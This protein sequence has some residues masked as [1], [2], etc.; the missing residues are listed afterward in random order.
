M[1]R[2]SAVYE[3]VVALYLRKNTVTAQLHRTLATQLRRLVYTVTDVATQMRLLSSYGK[4]LTSL[5]MTK[6]I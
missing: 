4:A 1:L 6:T 2:Y 5:L 3:Y